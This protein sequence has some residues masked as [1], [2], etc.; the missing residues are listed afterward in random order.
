MR[1]A[2]SAHSQL[3]SKFVLIELL[4]LDSQLNLQILD[5]EM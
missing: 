2:P 1:M 4:S 3:V 5:R